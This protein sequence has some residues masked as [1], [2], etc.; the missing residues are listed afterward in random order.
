MVIELSQEYETL[1]ADLLRY[2]S[3]R[4]SGGG[5]SQAERDRVQ[6]RVANSRSSISDSRANFQVAVRNLDRLMGI[7]PESII[8]AGPVGLTIPDELP[9]ARQLG[10]DRNYDLIVARSEIDAANME[11][12][13]HLA[14][15]L[16]KFNLDF[17]HSTSRNVAGTESTFDDTKA[18]V[19]MNLQLLNGDADIAQ[20]R[21]AAARRGEKTSMAEG[22]ERKLMQD[23]DAAY[24]NLGAV[25]ERYASVREE[26]AA[27]KRVV[28]AF[29]EQMLG[30]NRSLLDVL[31][32]Y[33]RLYQSKLDLTQLL[34]NETQ[35]HL[36]VAHLTGVLLPA[37]SAAATA[38]DSQP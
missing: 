23:L 33:Q 1:L 34:I 22:V 3:E 5:A 10:R 6:A 15:F 21:A 2:I 13:S 4:A 24:A 8:V 19:V 36:K 37:L 27:N 31:D 28:A 16:P 35:L 20:V 29:K 12:K 30:A 7:V 11:R 17:S 14:K 18:M 38:P 25:T 32:A 26:L 9:G